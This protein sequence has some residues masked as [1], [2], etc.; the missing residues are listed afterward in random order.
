MKTVLCVQKAAG[1]IFAG[2]T[3]NVPGLDVNFQYLSYK[4]DDDGSQITDSVLVFCRKV[5]PDLILVVPQPDV[6]QVCSFP[7]IKQLSEKGYAVGVFWYDSTDFSHYIAK[8]PYCQHIILDDMNFAGDN[9]VRIWTPERKE[10]KWNL[11][12]VRDIPVSFN[13]TISGKERT[14]T[15]ERLTKLGVPIFLSVRDWISFKLFH[16]FM[17]R[18]RIG[19]NF[20]RSKGDQSKTQLK[21]RVFEMIAAGVLLV[22]PENNQTPLFFTPGEECISYQ[23]PEEGADKINYYLRNE[24]ERLQITLKAAQRMNSQYNIYEWWRTLFNQ[25]SL[26][27]LTMN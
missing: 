6:D 15:L 2:I 19:L 20:P 7:W 8:M 26:G 11:E 24:K 9:V 12:A 18:T 3:K 21:G 27:A 5:K 16:Q 25:I 1:D 14:E 17:L 4:S 10:A 22:D 13:G 23:T